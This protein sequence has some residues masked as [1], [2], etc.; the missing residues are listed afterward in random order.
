MNWPFVGI[1]SWEKIMT[2]GEIMIASRK[3][4]LCKLVYFCELYVHI[5]DFVVGVFTLTISLWFYLYIL[6]D[7]IEQEVEKIEMKH[8]ECSFETK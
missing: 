7:E 5:F 1:L 8:L 2:L 3:H 6:K 4:K